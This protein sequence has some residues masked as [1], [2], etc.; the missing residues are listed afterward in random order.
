MR[1]RNMILTLM[2][3]LFLT[4][5]SFSGELKKYVIDKAHSSVEF[6][7]RHMAIAKVKGKFTEFSGVIMA[8]EEDITN[9]IINVTIQTESINTENEGRDK[10]LKSP[11]FFQ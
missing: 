8:D 7:V 1:I 10:H 5:L 11:D 6:T 4:N 3:S 2:I 9:S